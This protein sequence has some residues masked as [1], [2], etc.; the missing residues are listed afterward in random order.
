MAGFSTA[1]DSGVVLD[2][3]TPQL[4]SELAEIE[5]RL[6]VLRG[7]L[8]AHGRLSEVSDAVRLAHSR[9]EALV[10]LQNDPFSYSREQA[11]AVLDMPFSWQ[12]ADE[13]ERLRSEWDLVAAR[14]ASLRE[15][16][17]EV[18]ALHWFG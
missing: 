18:L 2:L 10:A 15:Q 1:H 6:H 3:T 4:S 7:L 16:V 9:G 5:R 17:T 12:A 8:D 14:R 11:E 13:A